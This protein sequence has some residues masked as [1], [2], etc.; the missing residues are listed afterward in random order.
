MFEFPFAHHLSRDLLG[1]SYF[2]PRM[3]SLPSDF[4]VAMR[5]VAGRYLDAAVPY[6]GVIGG[7]LE[8]AISAQI[9]S[10]DQPRHPE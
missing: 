8:G 2:T 3:R 1:P 7:V 5:I 9:A 6:R 4:V 10:Y